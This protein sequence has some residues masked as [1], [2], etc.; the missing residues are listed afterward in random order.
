MKK[1]LL[2]PTI[3]VTAALTLLARDYLLE[4]GETDAALV[5]KSIYSAALGETRPYTV[6][7]PESYG[8]QPERHYPVVYVLDGPSQETHT[9]A[10]AALMARIEVTPEVIVVGIPNLDDESRQRDLTPPGMRQVADVAD[11]DGGRGDRFLAFIGT[12]LIPEVERGYRT[13]S[14]RALAGHSRSGLFVVYALTAKPALFGAYL[15]NSPA[16]WRDGGAMVMRLGRFL[17][18]NRA[19]TATLHLSLGSE[20]N[21]KMKAAF[22]RTVATLEKRA[23]ANLRWHAQLTPGAGHNDNAEL[24]TPGALRLAFDTGWRPQPKG[25]RTLAVRTSAR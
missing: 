5:H 22:E 24:A 18:E 10:S 1:W 15:A 4:A 2:V 8:Q 3:V 9:A 23:P 16:M 14:S 19:A 17:D 11:S 25:T 12:E 6:R 21:A 7:L 20:E 13:S